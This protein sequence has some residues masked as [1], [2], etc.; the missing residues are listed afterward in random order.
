VARALL[1]Y[2]GDSLVQEL[3]EV[4]ETSCDLILDLTPEDQKMLSKPLFGLG[5]RLLCRW[6]SL[7]KQSVSSLR[8][9]L[10]GPAQEAAHLLGHGAAM[11][12]IND[13]LKG[14]AAVSDSPF[15]IE[16][17][18][19]QKTA[20]CLHKLLGLGRVVCGFVVLIS[21]GDGMELSLD[22]EC[23]TDQPAT[24]KSRSVSYPPT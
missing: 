20:N 22:S 13:L 18:A 23:A 7:R 9:V 12:M 16:E 8:Q 5:G 2:P 4:A 11:D 19:R 15:D 1:Y 21:V 6:S 3:G 10:N 17:V 24:H 14:Q